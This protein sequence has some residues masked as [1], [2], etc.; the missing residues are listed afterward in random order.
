MEDYMS[1]TSKVA[2]KA[3]KRTAR[4]G[5]PKVAAKAA[6]GSAPTTW[7]LRSDRTVA[8]GETHTLSD[9]TTFVVPK[10]LDGFVLRHL[11]EVTWPKCPDGSLWDIVHASNPDG[12]RAAVLVHARESVSG[13]TTNGFL[14]GACI[15]RPL[16]FAR[17]HGFGGRS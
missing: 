3:A 10:D 13:T 14:A 15:V 12:K 6:T 5:A 7:A 16:R 8:A 11:E 9:G 4:K 2:A 1:D 17:F